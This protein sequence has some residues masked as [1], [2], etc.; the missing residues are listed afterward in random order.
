MPEIADQPDPIEPLAHPVCVKCGAPGMWLMGTEE[1]YPGYTR[2]L[3]ECPLCGGTMTQWVQD[4]L[5]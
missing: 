4:A 3:F 5:D 2:R 1:Q